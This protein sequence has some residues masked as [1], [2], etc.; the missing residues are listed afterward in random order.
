[1][2]DI[3]NGLSLTHPMKIKT[4]L[5]SLS[6]LNTCYS[7]VYL[8]SDASTQEVPRQNEVFNFNTGAREYGW[9]I[10]THGSC[11]TMYWGD[12]EE[13][14]KHVLALGLSFALG[15]RISKA[16][17]NNRS[18]SASI[19]LREVLTRSICSYTFPKFSTFIVHYQ[20]RQPITAAA[21]SKA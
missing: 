15:V 8:T 2:A 13:K 3:P 14:L 21:R 7:N 1:V 5:F 10:I 16:R 20:D 9:P 11:S 18:F 6:Y 19:F 17:I 12:T 4:I